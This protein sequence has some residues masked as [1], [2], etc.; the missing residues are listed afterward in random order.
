MKFAPDPLHAEEVESALVGNEPTAETIAAA[1]DQMDL[2]AT[3][4]DAYV[5]AEYRAHLANVMAK[6]A[7]MKAVERAAG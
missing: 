3:L 4:G 2:Q 5:S 1:T 6:R 7:L